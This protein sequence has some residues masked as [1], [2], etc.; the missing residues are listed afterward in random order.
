[1]RASDEGTYEV[2]AIKDRYCAFSLPGMGMGG[3]GQGKGKSF[4]QKLLRQ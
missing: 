4:A 1:M 3:A 2:I